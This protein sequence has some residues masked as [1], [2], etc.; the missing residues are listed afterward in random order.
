MARLFV[1]DWD[2]ATATLAAAT[3]G[4]GAAKVDRL[5][6]WTEEGYL[7]VANAEAAGKALRERLAGLKLGAA[8]LLVGV[9]RD[10]VV[11]KEIKFPPVAP[12]EEPGIVRFQALKELTDAD[13]SII[14]YQ[15][16]PSTGPGE[17]RALVVAVKRDVLRAAQLFAT[18]A[19][20]KLHAVVPRSYG[21]VAAVRA[22][23]PTATDTVAAIVLGSK[24]GEFV[25]S[26]GEQ[27]L[28]A[29]PIPA[30]ATATEAGLLAEVRR[31]LAV[32]SAQ[33]GP[34]PVKSVFVFEGTSLPGITARLAST[35]AV[36]VHP[37][38]EGAVHGL[39]RLAGT[40]ELPINFAKP[41]EPKPPVDP[42]RRPI[43]IGVA[44]AASL[45]VACA[46]IA[47]LQISAKD[48]QIAALSIEKQGIE[49]KLTAL[50]PDK[51]R[52]KA[53]D[54]WMANDIVWLDELYDLAA[55]IPDTT[56]LRITSIT[57][58]PLPVTAKGKH[59]ARVTIKG[60]T[61]E[62][63]KPLQSFMN[64]L[65]KEGAY[66]VAP[67]VVSP[68]TMGTDRRTFSQQFS[69]QFEMEKRA[70]EKYVHHFNA[71]PPAKRQRNREGGAAIMDLL[72]GIQ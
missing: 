46:T 11:V 14:D 64:E 43:L 62:D 23:A 30:A 57:A 69:T 27:I 21:I 58:D 33:A 1:L 65:V 48:K 26:H 37:L 9:P 8:P 42:S 70:P 34:N 5:E 24:G 41:R 59:V 7:T 52:A 47:Y 40:A 51:R 31:N 25:V 15:P 3:T 32:Y 20:L 53:L 38:A 17:R 22:A 19:G 10:R 16:R 18:G 68:N 66:K 28:F 67:K 36:P 71:E 54:D 2:G 56:K 50:D 60:L 55:R 44:I 61:T 72:G 13:D 6:T 4:R 49:S 45:L 12:H 35:L 39:A 63:P 29:R